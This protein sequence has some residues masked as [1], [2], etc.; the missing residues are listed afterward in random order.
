MRG[1]VHDENAFALGGAS[2]HAGLFGDAEAV[3]GFAEAMLRGEIL[4]E[5]TIHAMLAPESATRLIGWE[6]PHEGWHGGALWSSRACGHTGFTGVALYLDF[7]R[8]VALTLLTNRVH[9]S[10]HTDSGIQPLRRASCD[11]FLS[12]FDGSAT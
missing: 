4:R 5:E 8:G 7:E 12:C 11:A 2:G 9:P 6:R 3:M 10:R 1:E